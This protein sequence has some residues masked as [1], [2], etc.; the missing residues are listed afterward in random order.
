MGLQ[1]Y[2]GHRY[3]NG[4]TLQD[5]TSNATDFPRAERS[6]TV[7]GKADKIARLLR[8]DRRLTFLDIT[9]TVGLGSA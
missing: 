1:L 7:S 9:F 3:M 4:R 2:Q 8:A 6:T 5:P